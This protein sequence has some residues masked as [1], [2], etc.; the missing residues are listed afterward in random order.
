[1]KIIVAPNALKGSASATD[2][3]AAIARG[4]RRVRP[5]ATIERLPIS[6]GGDGFLDV[7]N[8]IGSFDE[9]TVRVTGP[10]FEPVTARFLFD[11]I[12]KRAMIAMT[13]ASGMVLL[14]T[15]APRD[16]TV[17]TTV[18]TGELIR[19]ALDAGAMRIVVG[20]GGSA[21]ND[22]G[23]GMA[24]AL[25]WTF[26]R[27]NDEPIR[28]V[29]GELHAIAV[30]DSTGRDPRLDDIQL[31]VMCDVENP[32]CGPDGASAVYGPQKGATPDQ[33]QLLDAGLAHLADA[34]A[35]TT[36]ID[37]RDEPGAGAAGGIGFG[38]RAF[39]GA[40]LRR[41][42]EILV[43]WL[44]L[45]DR[46][47]DAD[48]IVTAEGTLDEQTRMGKGP[49]AIADRAAHAGVPCIAIAGTVTLD[50]AALHDLGMS[51]AFSLRAP[52]MSID[53]SITHVIPLLEDTAERALR[54]HLDE[55][56]SISSPAP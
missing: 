28:P 36:G 30:L 35:R 24:T 16:P 56:S 15:D 32:L 18:G 1:M 9:V 21:T 48:L 14:P 25:G 45:D 20:I 22:G 6:D 3:A 42:T 2:A 50:S 55:A 7:A 38:L 40:H 53:E 13:E 39:A 33:V 34:L 47:G 23:V 10:R 26:L 4:L 19:A 5:N 37:Q 17:T 27:A 46:L 43:D 12:Q 8:T 54:S 29:G 51:A 41:G 44:A 49:A 31:D 11:R 52:G